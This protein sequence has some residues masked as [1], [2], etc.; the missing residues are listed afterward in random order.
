MMD[1]TRPSLLIR[2]RDGKDQDAWREFDSIY[3][4]MLHS[5]AG[6]SGLSASDAEEL[7][8]Q[9]MMLIH[10]YIGSFEYDPSKGRF[11]SWLR[12]IVSNRTKNLHRDRR[13]FQ[14]ESR[15]FGQT[16]DGRQTPEELFDIVW[17]REHLKHCVRMAQAEVEESTFQVFVAH[18]L[19]EQPIDKVCDAFKMTP[20]QVHAIKSRM[21]RRVRAKMV[22]ILGEEC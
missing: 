6:A 18:V 17:R 10:R 3:R 12:T 15:Q 21:I 13:E 1:T 22:E 14:G 19:D 5:F 11:K 8:Q 9:C 2:I 20:N 4:P 7:A 16:P